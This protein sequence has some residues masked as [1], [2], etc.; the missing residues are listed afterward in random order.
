MNRNPASRGSRGDTEAVR[1]ML[2]AHDPAASVR[3]DPAARDLTRIE[4]IASGDRLRGRGLTPRRTAPRLALG[5][6][7]AFTAVAVL[8]TLGWN[9]VQ[10]AYAGP[11]PAPLE[12]PLAADAPAG[13]EHLLALAEAAEEQPPPPA[14]G[15][16]AYVHTAEWT[17]TYSQDADTG[18]AGWGVL[19]TD[20]QVWRTPHRSGRSVSTPSL[21]EHGG[22]DPAPLRWLF[23]S[24]P[25]EFEWGGGEGGNGMFF[26]LEPDSLSADPDQLAEQLLAVGGRA[27]GA[28]RDPSPAVGLVYAL[29]L[30]Y[31]EA[32]VGPDVQAAALRALAGQEDVRYAGTARDRE[33]REGEL[34]L[35]EE[36]AGDGIVL[37][38]RI[39]FD[40]DT[41]TPLYH[42]TVAVESPG[43]E[44][45]PRVNNYTVLVET[46]WVAEVGAAP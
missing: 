21:P 24:G 4:A 44:G 34:F 33:G 32:P 5:A 31:E 41:G 43:E 30:L 3:P 19:P 25:E 6:A 22:G 37:E 23:E 38:R 12:V 26:T 29:Q 10:P 39:M 28:T 27:S 36:D 1:G 8:G 13:R 15:E 16:V 45:L 11:P 20:E 7:A 35:V 18:E 9:S 17:L 42:E 2:A 46:A 40:A 14:G